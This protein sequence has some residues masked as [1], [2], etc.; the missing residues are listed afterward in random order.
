MYTGDNANKL[1]A[2]YTVFS[3]FFVLGCIIISA[4]PIWF[5]AEWLADIFSIAANVSVKEQENGWLWGVSFLLIGVFLFLLTY[6]VLA[7]L[8]AIILGWSKESCVN[9]FL[10]AKYPAHW[11]KR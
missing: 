6:I 2:K 8:I 3:L 7:I 11:Y 1:N 10:K 5:I 9:I 4:Y